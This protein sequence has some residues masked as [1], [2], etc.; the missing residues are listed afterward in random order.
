VRL[1]L[2]QP[3]F[4]RL[5]DAIRKLGEITPLVVRDDGT[6]TADRQPL[7]AVAAQPEFGWVSSDAFFSAGGQVLFAALQASHNLRWVHS[8]A[9]GVDAPIWRSLTARGAVLTTADGQAVSIAEY[10]MGEVLGHF[11]RLRERRREQR[12]RR[13]T[14][15]SFREVLG[16]QWVIVGFGAIGA[17][18]AERAAA[19]G[20]R[21]TAVRRSQATHPAYHRTVGVDQLEEVLP[22]ADVVVLATPLTHETRGIASARFFG[23]L[24]ERA[25]LV[26]VGRGDL[27]D[28]SALLSGLDADKPGHAILDVFHEEPPPKHHPFWRHPKVSLSAHAASKGSG[29]IIRN[30]ALFL[31]NLQRILKGEEMLR[32]ADPAAIQR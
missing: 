29:T 20:T 12:A 9:A 26:N 16:Q 10:V 18:I 11:Q 27:V 30:D 4:E 24:K 6:I 7:D 5:E 1:I 25:V 31:T 13:W 32:I 8:N 2:T 23:A 15:L 17:A 14:A 19:F 28:E 21:I 3:A 22:D